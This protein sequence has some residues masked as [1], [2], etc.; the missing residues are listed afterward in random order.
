MKHS[1]NDIWKLDELFRKILSFSKRMQ[2]KPSVNRKHTRV[3]CLYS[4]SSHPRNVH[5]HRDH[6]SWINHPFRTTH[7]KITNGASSRL[8]AAVFVL[9][10]SSSRKSRRRS[11]LNWVVKTTGGRRP[12]RSECR[13]TSSNRSI[14]RGP[15]DDDTC[16]PRNTSA[17]FRS[18]LDPWRNAT[19]ARAATRSRAPENRQSATP[20]SGWPH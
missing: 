14:V 19:R 3:I 2:Q 12:A 18:P 9:P 17:G 20:E 7:T 4:S 5:I 10:S 1:E 15:Q 6:T 11:L 8:V 13:C 16:G